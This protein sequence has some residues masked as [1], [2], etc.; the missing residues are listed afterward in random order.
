MATT[1]V[2]ASGGHATTFEPVVVDAKSSG[3][4]HVH[5]TL[6]YFKDNEDGSEPAPNYVGK[7]ETYDRPIQPLDVVVQD[8]TGEVDKYTLDKNGF[9]IYSHTSQE[10]DFL[11][12]DKIKAEYYPETEQLLKD[13]Y[14]TFAFPQ[15][16]S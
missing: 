10:K 16:T 8:I 9:Q 11:D 13:A 7:P 4:H 12:D 6:N 5:T 15:P 1:T 2:Q 14:V 3:P